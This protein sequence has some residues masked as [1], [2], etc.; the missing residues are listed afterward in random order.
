MSIWLFYLM[1]RTGDLHEALQFLGLLTSL[2]C[3]AGTVITGIMKSSKSSWDQNDAKACAEIYPA[4]VKGLKYGLLALVISCLIPTTKDWYVLI[5]GYAV[6]HVEGIG[7]LPANVVG[8]ANE[9][10][11][12]Y[13][14]EEKKE[15][16]SKKDGV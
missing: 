16:K 7:D 3:G 11:K 4:A 6:T 15:P 1:T 8:A 5:G 12:Q 14:P 9:F 2:G 13:Q 10:L